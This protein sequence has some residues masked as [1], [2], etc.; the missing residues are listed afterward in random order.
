MRRYG[1]G[2]GPHRR[3]TGKPQSP[4][5]AQTPAASGPRR[6]PTQPRQPASTP[7]AGTHVH[8]DAQA[9][10]RPRSGAASRPRARA[11]AGRRSAGAAAAPSNPTASPSHGRTTM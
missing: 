6:T 8:R 10:Q 1:A 9:E 2:R 11:D 5:R 4:A 3:P 7:V